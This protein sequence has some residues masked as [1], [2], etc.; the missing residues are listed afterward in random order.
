M[1]VTLSLFAGVGAQ[2]L[3]NNGVILSGGLV[4]TYSAGT[5]TPLTTYTTNLGNVAHPNPI[6]LDSAGRITPGGEMWLTTGYGYKFVVK[7]SN[8]VL[9]ASY[10]NVPSSAQ[11]LI[12]NDASSIS[13]EQGAPT[14]AG[15]FV[16]GDTYLITSIGTTNFQ[17][18]GA[19]S[20]TV[21]IH[22]I[23]TGVGSG[24]GTAAFSRTVQSKFQDQIS[25]KDFGAVGD[26]ITDDTQAIQN[27]IDWVVYQYQPKGVMPSLGSVYMPAG[28]YKITK[29][30]QLGYGEGFH[31][32][33]LI[34]SGQNYR[35]ESLFCGTTIIP[36]F[37][38]APAIAI[39]AGRRTSISHL[40]IIGQNYNWVQSNN[41]GGFPAPSIDDLV[42]SIW[43]DPSFPA[44]SSS[45]YT[46]Y[47]AIAIDPYSG[48]QP[49]VHYPNV[50]FPSW[51]GYST[52]YGKGG[53]S[54]TL[55]EDVYIGG[56]V[57]GIAQQPSTYDGNGDET[58][59]LECCIE[60]CQY[61]ISVGN[62]Q[63]RLFR[64]SNAFIAFVYTGFVTAVNGVQNGQP[65]MYIDSSEVSA[66][67]YLMNIPTM[68]YGGG[69]TFQNCYS[70]ALY[71]LGFVGAGGG[72]R[73]AQP[74][75]FS[76]CEYFFDRTY[77]GVPAGILNYIGD[78]QVTFAA[79]TFNAT[80]EI[81]NY[82][83]IGNA[84][85]YYFNNCYF[86]TAA[87]ST[88]INYLW[89]K[90]PV[91][92]T[93]GVTFSNAASN[94]G[95]FSVNS[96]NLW[97]LNT[98]ANTGVISS[99]NKD[100]CSVSNRQYCIP[101]YTGRVICSN[102]VTSGDSGFLFRANQFPIDKLSAA[103]ITTSGSTV[104]VDTTGAIFSLWQFTQQGFEVG[105]FVVDG[106][107]N[108]VFFVQARTGFVITL[109][110]QNNLTSTGSLI[111]PI[112]TT[113]YFYSTNCRL[114]TLSSLTLGTYT[115]SSSTI[116]NFQ[117][118]DGYTGYIN[119]ASYGVQVG[120]ALWVGDNTIFNPVSSTNAPITAIN[121][122]DIVLTGAL[123]YSQS[124]TR[125]TLFVRTPPANNT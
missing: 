20:N 113:G 28:Q 45:Q 85:N 116:S 33:H 29:T 57:V 94:V 23:A 60:Y 70:E 76:G 82:H 72:D 3:D 119:N 2:F 48:T 121:T 9:I 4:Y 18:I 81:S 38:N 27:A 115:S 36:T 98:G 34:G 11:P 100:Y 77:R 101:I 62:S 19:A 92:A 124:P 35:G 49:T 24:T 16:I 90:F 6:V 117:R 40:T 97:D 53:S 10:D 107:T 13:Y 41:L 69:L 26:G 5:T 31:S 114:N 118:P 95:S 108:T 105:D 74:I 58:K 79:C 17:I 43:V 1:S 88:Y 123:N 67:I 39:N 103:S 106:P 78:G 32:V 47:C 96:T 120:D 84:S 46:P 87:T 22:F 68:Q 80:K 7:D 93:A 14:T 73:N 109:V 102:G 125:Q 52:Q 104:T 25:V 122:N 42:A 54:Q 44:S 8:G 30:L 75:L 50:T 55:I 65:G 111:V 21:G 64:V 63:S 112:T 56:F 110:A 89:Q 59:V 66:S 99:V 83:F 61:A 15:S 51:L 86:W 12:T 71:S 91:N 37:N